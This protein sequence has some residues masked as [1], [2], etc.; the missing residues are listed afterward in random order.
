MLIAPIRVSSCMHT[1]KYQITE[2]H[3]L[4][5]MNVCVQVGQGYQAYMM[6]VCCEKCYGKQASAI[7]HNTN[8]SMVICANNYVYIIL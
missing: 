5:M 4:T 1:I 3:I 6:N 8:T 7:F 2:P